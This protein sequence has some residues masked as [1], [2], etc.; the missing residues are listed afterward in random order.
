MGLRHTVVSVVPTDDKVEA[1][2]TKL[3]EHPESSQFVFE[4]KPHNVADSQ[5]TAIAVKSEIDLTPEILGNLRERVR[6]V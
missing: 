2:L 3:R 6:S 1:R 5:Q 4:T